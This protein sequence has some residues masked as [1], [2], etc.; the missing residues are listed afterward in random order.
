M[1]EKKKRRGAK[2]LLNNLD[3]MYAMME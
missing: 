3:M 1:E 2:V